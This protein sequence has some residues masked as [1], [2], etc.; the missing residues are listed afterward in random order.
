[1]TLELIG[2]KRM[3]K[4]LSGAVKSFA[5]VKIKIFKLP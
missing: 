1:M 2:K 5:F 3:R 4:K